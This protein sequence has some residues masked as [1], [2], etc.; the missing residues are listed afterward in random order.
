MNV[1]TQQEMIS[2]ALKKAAHY[3]QTIAVKYADSAKSITDPAIQKQ[4]QSL[5]QTAR[6]HLNLLTQQMQTLGIQ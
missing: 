4:L 3:E 1:L 2:A 6:N 5:E